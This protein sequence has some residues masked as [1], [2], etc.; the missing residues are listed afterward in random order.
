[1]LNPRCKSTLEISQQM[2]KYRQYGDKD[3]K[4]F[5]YFYETMLMTQKK[6]D[7]VYIYIYLYIYIY[8]YRY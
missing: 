3:L 8:I 7:E 6:K 5:Q 1:M 2:P 4:K